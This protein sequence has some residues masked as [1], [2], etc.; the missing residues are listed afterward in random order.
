MTKTGKLS[1]FL[2]PKREKKHLQDGKKTSR[3]AYTFIIHKAN[4]TKGRVPAHGTK[5]TGQG[6]KVPTTGTFL[7][8]SIKSPYKYRFFAPFANFALNYP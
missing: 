4:T 2:H 6:K 1:V 3:D 8:N 5:V 7:I